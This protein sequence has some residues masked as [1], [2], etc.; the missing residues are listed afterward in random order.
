MREIYKDDEC[1]VINEYRISWAKDPVNVTT[2]IC[3]ENIDCSLEQYRIH[4]PYF[5]KDE[6]A[7]ESARAFINAFNAAFRRDLPRAGLE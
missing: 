1:T 4:I 7:E 6:V 3:I 2:D 5:V